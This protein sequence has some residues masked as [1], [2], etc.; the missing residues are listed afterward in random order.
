MCGARTGPTLFYLYL[1]TR[2]SINFEEPHSNSLYILVRNSRGDPSEEA[3]SLKERKKKCCKFHVN[4]KLKQIYDF[5]KLEYE[6]GAEDS[7]SD[8]F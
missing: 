2:L 8:R 1:T 6:D 5:Q 7:C 3:L 4:Y